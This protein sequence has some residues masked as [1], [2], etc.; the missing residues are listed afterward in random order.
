[1]KNRYSQLVL[2]QYL[3]T[4]TLVIIVRGKLDYG[5]RIKTILVEL[6]RCENKQIYC[7]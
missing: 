1:M 7:K 5:G 2:H 3:I 6:A 4:S